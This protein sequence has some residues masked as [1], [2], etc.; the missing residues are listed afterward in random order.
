MKTLAGRV[1]V[2]ATIACAVVFAVVGGLLIAEVGRRER[3]T[4]DRELKSLA[5][6]MQAPARRG[7]TAQLDR[8]SGGATVELLQRGAVVY[9]SGTNVPVVG[10]GL[11][12]VDGSRIIRRGRLI[13]AR[14]LAEVEQRI[15]ELR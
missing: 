6:R 13:V 8:L 15:A 2:L 14:P 1:T 10:P 7:Q 12:T 9:S 11:H 5:T 3:A 4:L